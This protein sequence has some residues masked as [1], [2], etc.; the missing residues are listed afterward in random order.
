MRISFSGPTSPMSLVT[1]CPRAQLACI[2]HACDDG[3]ALLPCGAP[4]LPPEYSRESA[5]ACEPERSLGTIPKP[6]RVIISSNRLAKRD[7]LWNSMAIAPTRARHDGSCGE[8][9]S[10]SVSSGLVQHSRVHVSGAS[11]LRSL[12]ASFVQRHR[13]YVDMQRDGH[14]RLI[15][16]VRG[17]G[18][19][20]ASTTSIPL[21][22]FPQSA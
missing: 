6:F 21:M 22:T 4:V 13:G 18:D 15:R 14:E 2:C 9:S 20:V 3:P 1:S 11:S 10:R 7:S 17:H 12:P 19:T 8:N 16:G 5:A